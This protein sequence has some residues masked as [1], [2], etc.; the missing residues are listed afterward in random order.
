MNI[1]RKMSGVKRK[2]NAYANKSKHYAKVF[3]IKCKQYHVLKYVIILF[4]IYILALMPLFRANYNYIDDLGRTFAGYRFDGFG[5]YGSD[6]L[7]IGLWASRYLTDI[8]PFPQILAAFI[9][10][11]AGTMLIFI[12][13]RE[14]P[15][16]DRKFHVR[17]IVATIPLALFPYFLECLC[18]KYDAPFM[19][20][21]VF[22]SIFPVLF[23]NKKEWKYV[24]VSCLS[25]LLM[26]TTYQA[27]SGIYP[28]LVLLVFSLIVLQKKKGS[29]KFLVLSI[30][31][32]IGTLLVYKL[33][34]VPKIN[35]YVSNEIFSMNSLLPGVAK[36]FVSYLSLIKSDFSYKW[37][38]IIVV[39]LALSVIGL[40]HISN[41]KLY[42]SIIIVIVTHVAMFLLCFGMYPAL[43]KPLF[44]PRGMLGFGVWVTIIFV[45]ACE[46]FKWYFVPS[47]VC[48]VASYS[49][50]VFAL[51]FGN[52]LKYEK[53]YIAFRE[54]MIISDINE[55]ETNNKN[56]NSSKKIK[57]VGSIG[58][59]P[60]IRNYY[61]IKRAKVM[62]RLIPKVL[63]D[64]EWF[65]NFYHFDNYYGMKNTEYCSECSIFKDKNKNRAIIDN[66]C[67]RITKK[68]EQIV[69]EARKEYKVRRGMYND[70]YYNDKKIFVVLKQ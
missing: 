17:D 64:D 5:R 9:M 66:T 14:L 41:R 45:A 55:I 44:S 51:S 22:I 52:V 61:N 39:A 47:I 21:S 26:R 49:F 24:L 8:S 70:I 1:T 58:Y 67:G 7:S 25:M 43:S 18:Y 56:L 16:D 12:I 20:L 11:L 35:T 33:F 4:T 62:F 68:N 53:N 27:S 69:K 3:K 34:L 15:N 32:Y 38:A 60:S 28:M 50:F 59:A 19:A 46:C 6:M 23:K 48:L 37:L 36:N 29:V 10:A 42:Q 31:S 54:Y 2:L 30:A 65:W 63:K 40:I 57:L 13:R